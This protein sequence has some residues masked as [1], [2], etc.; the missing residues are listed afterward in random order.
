MVDGRLLQTNKKYSHLKPRGVCTALLFPLIFITGM[1]R[2]D[3]NN[4]RNSLKSKKKMKF[5]VFM[6][7]YVIMN[8][9][10][11]SCVSRS[12]I[13]SWKLLTNYDHEGFAAYV[14]M[15]MKRYEA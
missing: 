4:D 8:C 6:F 13:L 1:F 14:Q 11:A 9:I 10:G 15:S 12:S 5:A 3:K 2:M 7:L